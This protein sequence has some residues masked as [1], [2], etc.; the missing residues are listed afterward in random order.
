MNVSNDNAGC[1]IVPT[2]LLIVVSAV[3]YVTLCVIDNQLI[4][5]GLKAY[6]TKTGY[7]KWT[8]KAGGEDYKNETKR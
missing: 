3:F 1:V 4:A 6:D 2:L 8:D 7:L 5:R